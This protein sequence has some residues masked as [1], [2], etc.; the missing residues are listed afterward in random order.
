METQ[1]NIIVKKLL[2]DNCQSL[3]AGVGRAKVNRC[4]VR[5]ATA[6]RQAGVLATCA[7]IVLGGIVAQPIPAQVTT[8]E[9]FTT[10]ATDPVSGKPTAK[11]ASLRK[12][13][14]AMMALDVG[15]ADKDLDPMGWKFQAYIH[16]VPGTVTT[17]KTWTKEENEVW[18]TCEHSTW[19]FLSWHRMELYY[20][21]RIMRVMAGD[22]TL[23][24]PYWNFG[25]P[26]TVATPAVGARIPPEFR[27][28]A[29]NSLYW[30]HRNKARNMPPPANPKDPDP[31]MP[32]PGAATTA[33][34][35]FMKTAFYTNVLANGPT[36]FGGGAKVG[37]MHGT[38]GSGKGALENVPHDSVHGAVGIKGDGLS[39]SDPDG[40]GLDPI[41]WPVHV[42]IDRAWACW[43]QLHANTEPTE[44]GNAWLTHAFVFWDAGGTATEPAAKRVT[45][46]GAQIIKIAAAPLNYMYDNNCNGF[47]PPAPAPKIRP[48]LTSALGTGQEG[49]PTGSDQGLSATARFD[50]IL[51]NEPVVIKVRIPQSMQARIRELA[52]GGVMPAGSVMLTFGG[53]AIDNRSASP[54]YAIFVG[55]PE[56]SFPDE[57]GKYYVSQ[58]TFF[59]IGHHRFDD[60]HPESAL[61]FDATDVVESLIASGEW[62]G[63]EVSVTL[64]DTDGLNTDRVGAP[65][66]SPEWRARFT[67]VKLTV[68]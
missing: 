33:V 3:L 45:L 30:T 51:E 25:V 18:E 4:N 39:M 46:T 66:A 48:V 19:F 6:T 22:P 62:S 32:L 40:A 52:R 65:P 14:A 68:Q 57:T 31:A 24:L 28:V 8:R 12:G 41:F 10:F 13:V 37:T 17:Q 21:E 7:V 20:F 42:N 44:A 23:S 34:A 26:A 29:N 35:A 15:K 36:T 47:L 61:G 64:V 16:G 9:D 56:G 63:D 5:P 53:I 38:T 59:G 67:S 58:L 49:M 43:Q 11:L 60:D 2:D 1:R 54:G 27:V 50:G 55:L